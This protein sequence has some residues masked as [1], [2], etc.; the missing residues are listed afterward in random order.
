MGKYPCQNRRTGTFY[1][2]AY[3]K[4][5]VTVFL[6]L[7]IKPMNDTA[8]RLALLL[9]LFW[10]LENFFSPQPHASLKENPKTL[11]WNRFNKKK[12]IISKTIIAVKDEKGYYPSVIGV[13]EVENLKTLRRLVYDTPLARLGYRIIHKDSPDSRGIDVALIY[14]DEDFRILDTSILRISSFKTRDI[15]YVKGYSSAMDDTLHVFVNHWPSKLSGEKRSLPRRMEAASLLK[16]HADSILQVNPKALIIAMGDFNDSPSSRPVGYACENLVNLA[17]ETKD[18][19]RKS[20]SEIKGTHKFR[21][22]WEMLDQFIVSESVAELSNME[23][24]AFLHLLQQDKKYLGS[25][26]RRTFNGMRFEGGASDHLPI[27]L[28]IRAPSKNF[29]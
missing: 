19:L 21:G 10:N 28:S 16:K 2:P 8:Y 27:L 22:K 29:N 12:D 23:V 9:V 15:L 17:L 20:S 13:C 24:L 4:P 26:T 25:K 11:T 7:K 1:P 14:R 5:P 18:S 6:A 3:I